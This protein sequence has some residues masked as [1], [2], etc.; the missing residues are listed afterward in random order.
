[1]ECGGTVELKLI[2][3]VVFTTKTQGR[4]ND[5]KKNARQFVPGGLCASFAPLWL[6]Y[7]QHIG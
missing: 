7:Y 2:P 4:H 1:M 5:T 3:R 6:M